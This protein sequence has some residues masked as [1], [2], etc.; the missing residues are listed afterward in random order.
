[1][2][3]QLIDLIIQRL[4]KSKDHLQEQFFHVRRIKV[5]RYFVLDDFLPTEI[6]EKIYA[7][8]PKPRQMRLLNS[9]GE[10]KLKYNHIKHTSRLLQDFHQAIQTPSIIKIIE[11]ITGIKNQLPDTSRLAGGVSALLKG[12][13][14]NPHLDNSHDVEKK[15]YRT[16]NL[17]YYV[18]PNWQP[19]N[20]G[21]YELW[22]EEVKNQIIVPNLFNR[23][24]VMETNRTSW[25]SVNPVLCDAPRCCIFNYYFSAQSPE[26][27]EY[28]HSASTLLFNRLIKAR[29][30]QKIRRKISHLRDVFL[31]RLGLKLI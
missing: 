29:P 28:F 17:L 18:S 30:E 10:L 7:E 16:V 23:L 20:G 21:N 8:F 12:H 4:N 19:E 6:A 13:Y 9:Y 5:S 26:T 22:D 31:K 1:M 15:F 25:H 14:I 2:K 3:A 11:D 24:I 27:V